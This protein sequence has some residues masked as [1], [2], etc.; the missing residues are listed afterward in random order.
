MHASHAVL[1]LH[2]LMWML[3]QVLMWVLLLLLHV[4]M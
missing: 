1:L 3:L 2:V 4:L